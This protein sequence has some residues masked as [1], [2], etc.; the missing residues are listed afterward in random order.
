MGV[1]AVTHRGYGELVFQRFGRFCG[2]LSAGDLVVT[3]LVT[4]ITELIAVRIGASF[5]GVPPVVAVGGG[6][7]LVAISIAV[8]TASRGQNS[9]TC[10]GPVQLWLK[11]HDI[12]PDRAPRQSTPPTLLMRLPT[13]PPELHYRVVG[14]AL[15][16]LDTSAGIVVDF[17]PDLIK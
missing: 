1:G 4:L 12:Y 9:V 13:L 5:F 17:I 16:L 8:P 15:V 3:N 10:A 11:V 2:W 7:A 6:V 14:R